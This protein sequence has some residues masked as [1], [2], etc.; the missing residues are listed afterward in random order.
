MGTSS[1]TEW[2]SEWDLSYLMRCTPDSGRHSEAEA[3]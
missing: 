3:G 1:F 2:E